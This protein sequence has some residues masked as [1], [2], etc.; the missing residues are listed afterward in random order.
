MKS[1]W[2]GKW[3]DRNSLRRLWLNIWGLIRE[4]TIKWFSPPGLFVDA[5]GVVINRVFFGGGQKKNIKR[6]FVWYTKRSDSKL[7]LYRVKFRI[8]VLKQ[9]NFK[10]VYF[11]IYISGPLLF[12]YTKYFRVFSL[13][14]FKNSEAESICSY[15]LT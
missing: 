4:V 6:D 15:T 3:G 9:S 7:P 5:G 12:L 11:L 2:L 13:L 10:Q 8:R 14:I 1:G